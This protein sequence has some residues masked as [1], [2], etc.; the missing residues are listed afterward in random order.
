MTRKPTAL[1]YADMMN[2]QYGADALQVALET[3][4]QVHIRLSRKTAGLREVKADDVSLQQRIVAAVCDTFSISERE[5]RGATQ[6]RRLA[7]PRRVWWAL[8][9]D[10][11]RMS[12]QEIGDISN[13]DHSSILSALKHEDAR[14]VEYQECMS[15]LVGVAANEIAMPAGPEL[16]LE[17]VG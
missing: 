10:R 6:V 9:R 5:L 16:E 17:A 1:D 11:M 2:E 15:R 14:G 3:V 4:R 8:L 7:L 13:R 12:H